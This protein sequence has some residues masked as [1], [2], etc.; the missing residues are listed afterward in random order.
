M[1]RPP[2]IAEPGLRRSTNAARGSFDV[3]VYLTLWIILLYGLSARQVVPGFGA[4]GSPAMLLVLPA[5]LIWAAGWLLPGSGLLRGRN[6]IR[7]ALLAY[8]GYQVLSFAVASTRSLTPLE[9][10]GAMRALLTAVAMAG[11]GLLVT[12]G[13]PTL[14]RLTTLIRRIVYA[15]TFVSVFGIVQ[16]FTR[17]TFQ[18]LVPGLVWN[19]PPVGL[20]ARGE[21][22]RPA[23]TTLHAIEFS[24]ITAA[25]LPL[26]I[27]FALYGR[28]V[29]QRRN[30]ACAA[31][32]IALAVPLSVSRTGVVSLGIA[33]LILFAG[34]RGRRL[35]NG[36]LSVVIAIPVLWVTIPGIVGT[37][38]GM[39]TDTDDDPSVQARINRV[40][41][42]IALI[43]ER[44]WFGLGNGTWSV[45]D[46]F[47][48]DNEVYVTTLE[49]GIVGMVLT[50]LFLGGTV[51]LALAVRGLPG[52]DETTRHL[53][54]AIAASIGGLS[55]SLITFDAFH[56]RILTGTLFLLIGAAGAL[57]Q[58]HR[59]SDHVSSL[60]R[61]RVP[62]RRDD[63]GVEATR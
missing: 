54:M 32:L 10:S 17:Q 29:H 58:M 39:F 31:G 11:V 49:M 56:Y 42:V 38:I 19:R 33:L 41:R 36:V 26:A 25:L 63:P 40:P 28:T 61:M 27:H 51:V 62:E 3:T 5:L 37:F 21:F 13:V 1:S 44:P 16:F 24:V 43:R 8:L 46:Y 57:W 35:I 55:I 50:T 22:G 45:E 60:L 48:I 30:A 59:G 20:A 52:V 15:V 47:L 7:V 14:P 6:P 12:D 53:A 23:A 18:F 4:I 2:P 34:W 9:T